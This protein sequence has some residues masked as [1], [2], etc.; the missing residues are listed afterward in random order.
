MAQGKTLNQ[1]ESTPGWQSGTEALLDAYLLKLG[2]TA[3]PTRAH[4][5]QKVI[6]ELSARAEG[7]AQEDLQE[8]AI[9]LVRD[10]IERRLA[11][12]DHRD[13]VRERREI[14]STLVALLGE[15]HRDIANALF[16]LGVSD[17]DAD[18]LARLRAACAASAPRP[19]PADAPLAM[20]VQPIE[21]RT[22]NPL[23]ALLGGHK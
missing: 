10:L 9:E 1:P 4:W 8:E 11:V 21:L 3:A 5:I 2:I 20:P 7:V 15:K 14:A 6:Q 12:I 23:R 19:V 18:L 22:L 13:P 17:D 16:D